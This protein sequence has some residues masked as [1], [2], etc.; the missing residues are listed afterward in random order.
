MCVNFLVALN[1]GF[2]IGETLLNHLNVK[3]CISLSVVF[4]MCADVHSFYKHPFSLFYK[5]EGIH[6]FDIF[7]VSRRVLS[8]LNVTSL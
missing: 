2:F 1:L 4:K 5:K 6:L 8:E 3:F 7:K